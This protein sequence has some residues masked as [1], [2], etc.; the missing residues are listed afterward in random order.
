MSNE[1]KMRI[2]KTGECPSLSGKSTLTYQIGLEGDKKVCLSLTGNT[3]KGIFN[4]DWFDIEEIY[5]LL[6]SQKKPITSGSL[7]GLFENRSSNS[8]G[9]F[10][11]MLLKL[12]LLKKS[13]GNKHYNLVGQAEY[14][15]VVQAL[16]E[17]APDEKPDKK[18]AGKKGKGVSND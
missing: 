14:K 1:Q 17:T 7:H 12:G 6:A 4:K 10:V 3:G 5:S 2:I 13:P 11:A 15:K 9:F 16:I 8:A 18:K